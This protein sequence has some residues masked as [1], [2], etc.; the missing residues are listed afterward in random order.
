MN[1]NDFR[2]HCINIL[3]EAGI[4][5]YE[6]QIYIVNP[7]IEKNKPYGTY[8]WI[9][10]LNILP[11][12]VKLTFEQMIKIFTLWEGYY[13]CWIDVTITKNNIEMN[14]SLRMRKLKNTKNI[15][16]NHPFRIKVIQ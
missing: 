5:D 15:G 14:T 7:I 10:K 2:Q 3:H 6:N 1:N 4:N 11:K 8:D 13:P 12:K 9:M 16:E